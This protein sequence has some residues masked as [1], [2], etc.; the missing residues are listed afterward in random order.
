MQENKFPPNAL[1]FLFSCAWVSALM[2][3]ARTLGE[4]MAVRLF[5]APWLQPF[6]KWGYSFYLWQG[7]GY[8]VAHR[9]SKLLGWPAVLI[10]LAGLVLTLGFGLLAAPLERLRLSR[11][12]RG[13]AA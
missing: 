10:W 4:G 3:M 8:A 6:M 1:F 7:L 12:P 2:L 13:A 11:G 5:R 9:M